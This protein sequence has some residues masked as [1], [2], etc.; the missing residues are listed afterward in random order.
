[1]DAKRY[2]TVADFAFRALPHDKCGFIVEYFDRKSMMWQLTN[3]NGKTVSEC[4]RETEF[5][6]GSDISDNDVEIRVIYSE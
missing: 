1:M 2:W 4:K 5:I 6:F 3:I